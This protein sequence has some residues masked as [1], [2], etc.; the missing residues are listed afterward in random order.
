MS[1]TVGFIT[2]AS[3][4]WQYEFWD[5]SVSYELARELMLRPSRSFAESSTLVASSGDDGRICTVPKG[6]LI[7]RDPACLSESQSEVN[8]RSPQLQFRPQLSMFMYADNFD[9][10]AYTMYLTCRSANICSQAT[11]ALHLLYRCCD[12]RKRQCLLC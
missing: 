2:L 6:V 11:G 1:L 9:V 7:Y 5:S 12:L 4:F 10:S 3:K 8:G